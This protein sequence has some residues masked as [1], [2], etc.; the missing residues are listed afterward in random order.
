MEY[1]TASE[2]QTLEKDNTVSIYIYL[3]FSETDLGLLL[4]DENGLVS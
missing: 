2:T 1:D 4:Q 3:R